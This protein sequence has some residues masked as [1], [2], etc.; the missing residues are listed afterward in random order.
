M[1]IGTFRKKMKIFNFSR[2]KLLREG[3]KVLQITLPSI[4]QADL[5]KQHPIRF[6]FKC[7]STTSAI[8]SGK[9]VLDSV[10]F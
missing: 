10:K 2:I 1:V 8:I 3:R 4:F 9:L 7:L 6:L 5:L